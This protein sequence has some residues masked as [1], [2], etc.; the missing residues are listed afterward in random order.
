MKGRFVA[1]GLHSDT[2]LLLANSSVFKSEVSA[3]IDGNVQL[4]GAMF[5]RKLDARQLQVDGS[6]MEAGPANIPPKTHIVEMTGSRTGGLLEASREQDHRRHFQAI[7]N[8]RPQ[9]ARVGAALS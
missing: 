1:A 7:Q 4:D 2:D 9:P 6:L 3:K 5:D 8:V